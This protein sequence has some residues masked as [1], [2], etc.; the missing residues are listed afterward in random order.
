MK[1]MLWMALFSTLLWTAKAGAEDTVS[2]RFNGYTA[3]AITKWAVNCSQQMTSWFMMQGYHPAKATMM[4]NHACTCVIDSFRETMSYKK[5]MALA[6][7]VRQE[8]VEQFVLIC[9]GKSEEM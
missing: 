7:A 3:Y 9:S 5:A 1:K 6:P 4:S 2:V 8:K